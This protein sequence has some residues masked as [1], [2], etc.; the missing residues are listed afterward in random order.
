MQSAQDIQST[1]RKYFQSG[2]LK[3]SYLDYGG[4]SL[5][6]LLMLH[7][8]M[9]DAE[10]F[11]KLA[12]KFTDWRV[13][14]LDQRGHGWS[15][16]SPDKNYS[17]E[18]YVEDIH[19]LITSELK[20]QQVTLL[21]HSL[22][23]IN[24]YQFAARYPQYVKAVIVEDIGAEID[25]DM[26]FIGNLPERSDTLDD[27]KEA[28]LRIGLRNVDYFAESVFEDE[29]GWGFR[30][31]LQGIP[32]ST[33]HTKGDWWKD[34]LASTCP[35]LLIHGKQ[36]FALDEAHA[37]LMATRRPHT[38]LVV[39]EQCGHD[40]HSTDLEGYTKAVKEFLDTLT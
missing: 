28:L 19:T 32:V 29:R 26:S 37:K 34:W 1:K 35:I 20:G 24:A 17:R 16:H 39:F 33:Q 9:N 31:D 30:S 18:S 25:V 3:L 23:G 14:G 12:A 38:S 4:E 7:G 10:T 21:G 8:H 40:I 13:I 22:G 15:E 2:N 11:T 27:L 6:V 5:N 36:S